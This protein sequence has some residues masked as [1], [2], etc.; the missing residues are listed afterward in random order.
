MT[1][2]GVIELLLTSPNTSTRALLD[3]LVRTVIGD[4][5][6]LGLLYGRWLAWQVSR[7]VEKLEK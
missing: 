3:T 5:T 4:I 7:F 2:I 1:F 6:S